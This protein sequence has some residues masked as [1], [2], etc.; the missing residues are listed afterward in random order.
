M[1]G[2]L[3]GCSFRNITGEELT[4]K[5]KPHLDKY[6]PLSPDTASPDT[7]DKQRQKDH[8]SHFILRLAFSA[9]EDLRRRFTRVETILFRLRLEAAGPSELNAFVS[10][11]GLDWFE[12]VTA[13]ERAELREDLQASLGGRASVEDEVW[14]KVDWTRVPDLVEGRRVVV[15]GGK[16]FVPGREQTSM[17]VAEFS[18]CLTQQL[19]VRRSHPVY[20]STLTQRSSRRDA[21]PASTRTTAS[22]PSSTTSPRTSSPPTAPTPPTAPSPPAPK[23]PPAT[24]TPSPGITPPAWRTCTAP[25][26]ATPT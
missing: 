26:A 2:E 21:S 7:R 11:L 6:L 19:E 15:H 17:I 14:V 3:E 24:S 5:M 4:N 18:R 22:P 8:Y 1:L 13:G 12:E 20:G 23:S 10:G 16:A 25:S 9:T